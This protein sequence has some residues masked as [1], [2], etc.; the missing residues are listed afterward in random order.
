VL[1]SPSLGIDRVNTLS[2]P[3]DGSPNTLSGLTRLNDTR[4]E[5]QREDRPD[6]CGRGI[7]VATSAATVVTAEVTARVSQYGEAADTAG[8]YTQRARAGFL[9]RTFLGSTSGGGQH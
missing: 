3:T 7:A 8:S 6:T 1:R 9:A 5:K 2:V 4:Q